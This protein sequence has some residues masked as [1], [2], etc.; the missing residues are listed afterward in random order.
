MGQEELG[1]P[2]DLLDGS[3]GAGSAVNI[4]DGSEGAEI[5]CKALK[6]GKRSWDLL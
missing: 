3:G 4:S 5:S 2:V 6:W 1:S